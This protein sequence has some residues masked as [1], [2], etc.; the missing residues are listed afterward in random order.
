MATAPTPGKGPAARAQEE[1]VQRT[2]MVIKQ[3]DREWVLAIDDLGP[4]D[5]L[6]SRKQTGLPVTPFFEEDKFGADSLMILYW[7]ARR[8]AGEDRLR[9]AEVVEEYP[10]YKAVADAG[11]SLEAF[12]EG[13]DIVDDDSPLVSEEK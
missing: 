10:S 12:E 7:M 8:K 1:E 6:I 9:Y 4:N 13:S 11:F 2:A 5:D 3:G